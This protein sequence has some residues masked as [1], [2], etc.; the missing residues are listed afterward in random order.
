MKL[1]FW[2][3]AKALVEAFFGIGF[4][5]APGLVGAM[6]GLRLDAGA[7]VIARLCGAVFISS[8][9]VLL[10]ARNESPHNPILRALVIGAAV[11][12]GIGFIATL[13]ASISGVWNALGWMPVALNLA[14]TLAFGY[15]LF[16]QPA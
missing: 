5:L 9:I 12:N 3:I 10:L 4:V 1:N 13:M 15:F 16:K 6:F 7:A 8:S 11:S 14:F 2:M